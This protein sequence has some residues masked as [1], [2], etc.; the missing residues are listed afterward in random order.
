MFCLWWG[1]AW[2]PNIMALE[3]LQKINLKWLLIFLEPLECLGHFQVKGLK[4]T[5]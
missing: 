4:N 3:G 2:D 1:A 5:L